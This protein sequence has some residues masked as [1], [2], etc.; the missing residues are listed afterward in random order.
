MSEASK[1]LHHLQRKVIGCQLCPRLVQWREQV[2]KKKVARY[3]GWDY[4]GKPVPSFGDPNARLLVVGLAPAAHG[5]NRTGRM[6]TGDRSGDWLYRTLYKFGFANQATS[7][8][9]DDG[10]LLHDCYITASARCAPPK[11]K[12]LPRELKDCRPYLLQ[13]FQLLRNV[14]VIVAL[15]KVA[16][17]TV[18]DAFRELE[19]TSMPKRPMFR[20]GKEYQLNNHQI[21]IASYHPSQQNTFTGKLTEKMFDAVFRRAGRILGHRAALNSPCSPSLNKRGTL[22]SLLKRRVRDEFRI[23]SLNH[24]S[25]IIYGF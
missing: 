15:G 7:V 10:L 17:D 8:S 4:W 6:F 19:L 24:K 20:H 12:L 16:F 25:D 21:L 14:R 3:G 22:P 5:G 11:N 18:F 2:A 23:R 13:E 9:R 1:R